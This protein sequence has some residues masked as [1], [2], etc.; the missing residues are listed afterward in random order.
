MFVLD[1]VFKTAG[2]KGMTIAVQISYIVPES[3]VKRKIN[4]EGIRMFFLKE[5]VF[6][7]F[8]VLHFL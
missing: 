7:N 1:V 6:K 4:I 3:F 5:Q 2:T 8:T